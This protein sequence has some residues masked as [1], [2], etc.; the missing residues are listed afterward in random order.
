MAGGV[1]GAATTGPLSRPAPARGPG[2]QVTAR[3]RYGGRKEGGRLGG[4]EGGRERLSV[5]MVRE[6][7][8]R[9]RARR[10]G[11]RERRL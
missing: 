10:K 5:L 11:E 1:G 3:A 2:G 7:A 6:T 9:V 4:R 8:W